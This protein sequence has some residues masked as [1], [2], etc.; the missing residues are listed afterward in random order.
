M[1]NQSKIRFKD[2]YLVKKVCY[3]TLIPSFITSAKIFFAEPTGEI[4]EEFT[5]FPRVL[6]LMHKWF[7]TSSELASLFILHYESSRTTAP[8]SPHQKPAHQSSISSELNPEDYKAS[9]LQALR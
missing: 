9:V 2:Q 3:R 6:F 5:S 7:T 1:Q 4:R 8:S